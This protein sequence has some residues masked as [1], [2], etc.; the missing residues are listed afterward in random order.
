MVGAPQQ[1]I[2]GNPQQLRKV[3]HHA[4]QGFLLFVL[5]LGKGALAEAAA[6]KAGVVCLGQAFQGVVMRLARLF[7]PLPEH[8]TTPSGIM[9]SFAIT[10]CKKNF[11]NI[12]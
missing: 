5:V 4:G 6:G 7:E 11:G 12:K 8:N 3:A 2:G 9:L 1:I 10:F